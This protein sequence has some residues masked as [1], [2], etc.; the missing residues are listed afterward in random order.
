MNVC[1]HICVRMPDTCGTTW[2]WEDVRVF[3]HSITE[4]FTFIPYMCVGGNMYRYA[5]V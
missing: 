4:F 3:K 5:T 1:M 2:V